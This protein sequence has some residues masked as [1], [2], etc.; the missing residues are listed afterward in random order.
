MLTRIRNAINVRHYVVQVPNTKVT[1]AISKLLKEENYIL[2]FEEFVDANNVK[3]F[4]LLLNYS[5]T[6]KKKVSAITCLKRVSKPSVRVYS[7]ACDM[8]QVLGNFGLAIVSTSKGIMTNMEATKRKVGGEI[9]CYV[10]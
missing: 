1:F 6:G 8:P 5:G 10:W 7:K 2:S 9:L 3:W 4:L